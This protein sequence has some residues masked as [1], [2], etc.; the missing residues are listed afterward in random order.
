MH[1][2]RLTV[3]ELPGPPVYLSEVRHR[4]CCG[5]VRPPS[6]QPGAQAL[7]KAQSPEVTRTRS[8]RVARTC[9]R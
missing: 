3:Q 6:A 5:P 4:Q 2:E 9:T 1:D 8:F 7:A